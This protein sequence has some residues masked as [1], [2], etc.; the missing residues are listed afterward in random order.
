MRV[1]T[2]LV[3]LGAAAL[4][5]SALAQTKASGA[6]VCKADVPAPVAIGD[7]PG[8]SFAIGKAQCTWSGF[9]I[10]GVQY[11][12]GVSV[13]LDEISGDKSTSNGYHTATLASGDKAVAH[14][15]GTAVSKDGKFV[16]GGG[17]WT[18][19]SGTGKLKGIKGKGTFKGTPNADGTVTYHVDGEYSTK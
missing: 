12:D 15:H 18:F 11:K 4:A 3:F 6:A 1:K 5:A 17:T 14:F 13:S 10:G 16:S 2:V 8:H 7:S 9:E 19:T